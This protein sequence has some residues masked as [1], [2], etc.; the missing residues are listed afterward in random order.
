MKQKTSLHNLS[1]MNAML[2]FVL[3]AVISDSV[4]WSVWLHYSC[5]LI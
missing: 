5:L 1:V 4:Y 3:C 2:F